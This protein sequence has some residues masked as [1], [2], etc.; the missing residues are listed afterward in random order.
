MVTQ[1]LTS[2]GLD[3]HALPVS[4]HFQFAGMPQSLDESSCESIVENKGPFSSSICLDATGLPELSFPYISPTHAISDLS[5]P[6]HATPAHPE[7]YTRVEH[8]R[9]NRL[10]YLAAKIS[11]NFIG[12]REAHFN[13]GEYQLEDEELLRLLGVGVVFIHNPSEF[14]KRVYDPSVGYFCKPEKIV[15]K[16]AASSWEDFLGEYNSGHRDSLQNKIGKSSEYDAKVEPLT[17]ADFREWLEV[18]KEEIIAREKGREVA[19]EAWLQGKNL[20]NY[21]KV[22]I[23]DPKTKKLLGG[24]IIGLN[25]KSQIATLAYVAFKSSHSQS[26]LA[27]RAFKEVMDWSL[28]NGYV[29]LSYGQDTNLYGHHLKLDLMEFKASLGFVPQPPAQAQQHIFKILNPDKFDASPSGLRHVFFFTFAANQAELHYLEQKAVDDNGQFAISFKS[30]SN[31]TTIR[32]LLADSPDTVPYPANHGRP[33][34]VT[35]QYDSMNQSLVT[36]LGKPL[37]VT[38]SYVPSL[39]IGSSPQ[40]MAYGLVA[41]LAS[42]AH[43]LSSIQRWA[44]NAGFLSH[45]GN[46]QNHSDNQATVDYSDDEKIKKLAASLDKFIPYLPY[47]QYLFAT[48]FDKLGMDFTA[49]LSARTTSCTAFLYDNFAT[50]HVRGRLTDFMSELDKIMDVASLIDTAQPT[51]FF[52]EKPQRKIDLTHL[53]KYFEEKDL[54]QARE[55]TAKW[56]D[57]FIRLYL[58]DQNELFYFPYHSQTIMTFHDTLGESLVGTLDAILSGFFIEED[59][60]NSFKS[61]HPYLAG[62]TQKIKELRM[63]KSS[64]TPPG[65]MKFMRLIL[66]GFSGDSRMRLQYLLIKFGVPVKRE[67]LAGHTFISF[68]EKLYYR[69]NLDQITSIINGLKTE[70]P[71]IKQIHTFL[72]GRITS[73]FR[74]KINDAESMEQGE[75]SSQK[76]SEIEGFFRDFFSDCGPETRRYFYNKLGLPETNDMRYAS[77]NQYYKAFSL[78]FIDDPLFSIAPDIFMPAAFEILEAK[79]DVSPLC[80][81][82]M[83]YPELWVS[84]REHIILALQGADIQNIDDINQN[85]IYLLMQLQQS[86][87]TQAL[88]DK[89]IQLFSDNATMYLHPEDWQELK[90]HQEMSQVFPLLMEKMARRFMNHLKQEEDFSDTDRFSEYKNRKSI[91]IISLI[92]LAGLF[93]VTDPSCILDALDNKVNSAPATALMIL[94][95]LVDE[96][97]HL[98][99]MDFPAEIAPL[100]YKTICNPYWE[101]KVLPDH[102]LSA[103]KHTSFIDNI[104]K[105]HWPES[106]PIMNTPSQIVM[107]CLALHLEKTRS[108]DFAGSTLRQGQ[109]EILLHSLSSEILILTDAHLSVIQH[110]FR[111]MR[112]MHRLE[113]LFKRVSSVLFSNRASFEKWIATLA[114]DANQAALGKSDNYGGLIELFFADGNFIK[115]HQWHHYGYSN[116]VV[117]KIR[118]FTTQKDFGWRQAYML[119]QFLLSDPHISSQRLFLSGMILSTTESGFSSIVQ[120]LRLWTGLRPEQINPYIELRIDELLADLRMRK[121]RE[122]N[123]KSYAKIEALINEKSEVGQIHDGLAQQFARMQKYRELF[124]Q[125]ST[126]DDPLIR[127]EI[128]SLLLQEYPLRFSAKTEMTAIERYLRDSLFILLRANGF[129]FDTENPNYKLL[130]K[131]GIIEKLSQYSLFVEPKGVKILIR[132][133]QNYLF[134]ASYKDVEFPFPNA[135]QKRRLVL[136]NRFNDLKKFLAARTGNDYQVNRFIAEWRQLWNFLPSVLSVD[137]SKYSFSLTHDLER[138]VKHGEEPSLTCQRISSNSIYNADGRPLS[139]ALL[140]QLKLAEVRDGTG[141]VIARAVVE[142][143]VNQTGDGLALLVEMVYCKE[144][145]IAAAATNSEIRSALLTTIRNYADDLGLGRDNVYCSGY[146]ENYNYPKPLQLEG[147]S[148][149][150]LYRDTFLF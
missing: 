13:P 57:E 79:R 124:V 35:Q 10:S 30:P 81:L 135:M 74:N 128:N 103:L 8:A 77:P 117:E 42:D 63:P 97:S 82:L 105:D 98:D 99:H 54:I 142:V 136:D 120:I 6:A 149:L 127:A 76:L 14:E 130:V 139:R 26:E 89:I 106:L 125:L 73:W 33:T 93:G 121:A 27:L 148:D 62:L 58:A 131:S 87:D 25:K 67:E 134:D 115:N 126:N 3:G 56:M 107:E 40:V 51:P 50:L 132:L 133:L 102:I 146:I 113:D 52:P 55:L 15:W 22:F 88:A 68:M 48:L 108:T 18:Y 137:G 1:I 24:A 72:S 16:R 83:K 39:L 118:S 129:N 34:F 92:K 143:T 12:V 5:S 70:S 80:A 64:K 100:F 110:L 84:H 41:Y 114:N 140:P 141:E 23:K 44:I 75:M 7:F 9:T 32:D 28:A 96:C 59:T 21:K 71:G 147:Y 2:R 29:I 138:W 112:A 104:Y 20:D 101:G 31:V 116:E 109:I 38:T 19:T 66:P 122:V 145:S 90:T 47:W 95:K 111:E 53:D 43:S 36:L 17:A 94:F 49:L 37:H 119:S 11:S 65:M 144:N 85:H 123:G 91:Q 46:E 150:P 69:L 78:H 86:D 45:G 4:Q 60:E 61:N